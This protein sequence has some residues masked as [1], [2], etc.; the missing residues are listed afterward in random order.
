[1]RAH[2]AT[3]QTQRLRDDSSLNPNL[4]S[5]LHIEY[6]EEVPSI[7]ARQNYSVQ[8]SK[9]NYLLSPKSFIVGT[10]Y[11][12]KETKQKTY[13]IFNLKE[14]LD[15][16]NVHYSCFLNLTENAKFLS[17][18]SKRG[19]KSVISSLGDPKHFF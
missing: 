4:N 6:I 13:V 17:S 16:I 10:K 14:L 15:P 2:Y 9:F 5:I 1:M 7:V 19:N 12:K 11:T 18:I 3:E 8:N